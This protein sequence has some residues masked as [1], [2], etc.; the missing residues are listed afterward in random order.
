MRI[1]SQYVRSALVAA[2]TLP[3]M[4]LLC[5]AQAP[6]ASKAPAT[7]ETYQ[8]EDTWLCKPG[9]Q[10]LCAGTSLTQLSAQGSG[11]LKTLKANPDAPIDCFYVYPTISQDPNGN[12][13][14]VPGPGE[15]T[16]VA[17]QFA[18]FA[19]VCRPFAPMYRQ[20]TLAG[21][22]SWIMGSP[23]TLDPALAYTDVLA[24]W[25]HYLKYENKGRGVV[26]IGHSQ[27][28]RM[29]T[30]LVQ[31]E[32]DGKPAQSQLVSALLIGFNAEVPTGQ[33]VG[34]TF[35]TLPLCKAATQTGCLIAYVSFR[36]TAPPP[37]NTRFGRSANP[38]N[39][40]AC[41]DPV[42]LSGSEAQ[43]YWPV[44]SDMLGSRA[45]PADWQ[46]MAAQTKTPLVA[47][48]GLIRAQCVNAGGASYMAVA[49]Q[50][51]APGQRP[52]DFPGEIFNNGKVMDD[53]GLHLI[54]INLFAGNLL[55]IVQKQ[56]AAYLAGVAKSK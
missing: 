40:V 15:K 23:V 34:G 3:G 4:A 9:R 7:A 56:S 8:S 38:A 30:Q 21:L 42:A 35:K 49:T 47:L 31:Q 36:D 52:H 1:L 43:A 46:A 12:S 2:L 29:L 32:I 22:R 24:A 14:L 10:D 45:A 16:A 39:D 55:E 27:G 28:S 48:P 51:S 18:M 19:S 13:S 41:V 5:A 44:P 53:W 11:V 54:D 25:K 20:V 50:P 33:N 26:L 37:A 17:Q 6:A